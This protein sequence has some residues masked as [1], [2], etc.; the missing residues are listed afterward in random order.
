MVVPKPNSENLRICG[1]YK[2]V[3]MKIEDDNYK[4]PNV[5]DMLA[6]LCENG[7]K[8]TIFSSLDLAG[9]FNQLF[10]DDESSEILALNTHKGIL[11]AR[12]LSYG[13][14]SAPSIFQAKMNKILSGIDNVF[15][16][17]DDVLIATET[18]REHLDVLK[19]VFERFKRYN[20]KLNKAKCSWFQTQLKY[21]G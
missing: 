21:L 6:K 17:V 9:A 1:D 2:K 12:R 16:Y 11:K 4:L 5:Q 10:L 8:P 3:N 13:V 15:C 20:V 18:A 19:S 7:R 14:K